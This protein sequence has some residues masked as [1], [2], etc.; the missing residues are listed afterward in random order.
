MIADK[1]ITAV[2]DYVEANAGTELATC[3][4]YERDESGELAY[5]AV[6]AQEGGQPEQFNEVML[7]NWEIPVLVE[8]KT[9]PEDTTQATHQAMTE[10][11]KD[12]LADRS[13]MATVINPVARF[14]DARGG[15]G[16]TG[17]E[18]GFRVTSFELE[19]RAG[20]FE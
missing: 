16:E 19:I 20:E 6:I 5:P 12:L 10:D 8:L 14:F 2:K 18:D 9:N 1:V 13:T 4:F 11:L 3:N 17:Q 7:G 15:Q